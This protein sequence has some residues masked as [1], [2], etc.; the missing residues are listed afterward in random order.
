MDTRLSNSLIS[1]DRSRL[2][3]LMPTMSMK[4]ISVTFLCVAV[5]LVIMV[6][7]TIGS[8]TSS[9]PTPTPLESTAVLRVRDHDLLPKWALSDTTGLK[10]SGEIV[11][12]FPKNR[13]KFHALN[14]ES[15][16]SNSK[17]HLSCKK[18][19][20]MTTIFDVSDAVRRQVKLKNWCL[21]VVFDKRSAELYDAG[22]TKGEGND[23]VVYLR[24]DDQV[25]MRNA[26]NFVSAL[27]WNHFGCKNIG[28]LY[29]IMHGAEVI[30]G[31][32][33]DNAL[34][35]WI[36]GAA[37]AG[38]PSINEAIPEYEEQT[39]EALEP[40]DHNWPTYD[41]Y[42]ALGAP[43]LPSWPRGL[44]LEDIKVKNC[45]DT[46]LHT[47]KIKTSS[48]AVLQSLA[49]Y[50]PDVDA[51]YRLTMPVPFFFKRPKQNK[52]LMIP[53]GCLTPYNAQATLHFKA[54]FFGLF[55]PITVSG[56]VT[57]IWR[58][59]IAQRL[60][61]DTGLQFG[62]IARPLV[63]QDRNVHSNIG[64]LG[65]EWD[66]YIKGKPLM[67][68]LGSWKG[69]GRTIVERT[70]E[71]WIALYERQ[72]VELLDVQLVQLWLQTLL[73][74]GYTF[75]DIVNDADLPTPSYPITLKSKKTKD[76]VC[77]TTKRYTFWTSDLHDGPRVDT[78]TV[79][80]SLG[81]T[82]YIAGA[83]SNHT[84]FPSVFEQDRIHVYYNLSSVIKDHYW[85]AR[86][87][88]TAEK[89]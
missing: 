19:A 20:V 66:L 2:M 16:G 1:R 84:P 83:K 11:R 79:L 8:L 38:A 44:P 77:T 9:W 18:W 7:I 40:K 86:T 48:I 88:V 82:V 17:P 85:N 29:A 56:R 25:A 10:F 4:T 26:V 75:P 36:P 21:V 41:P 13:L 53:K 3:R 43:T 61:W 39:I 67:E 27:P 73:D 65:S 28:Y 31:F 23:A 6:L 12:Q 70:E 62:F 37:P 59:F 80:A 54:G 34:K 5:T 49:D 71:L 74:I 55:L 76:R 69:K 81:H 72:Y 57:D 78:P 87:R 63:V 47:T 52:H 50:Q 33:D 30:W 45:S 46:P 68:F 51:I 35:F 24:P 89:I 14:P 58:S 60:F 22:W 15:T 64:D 42:P 32:E